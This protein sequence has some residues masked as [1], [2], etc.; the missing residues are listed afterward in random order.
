MTIFSG[1]I[2]KAA[3]TRT[4]SVG[5]RPTFVTDFNIAENYSD[6]SGTRQTQFYRVSL[7][8]DAGTKLAKYLTLGRP[9]QL[10]GRVKGRGYLTQA[11]V[12]QIKAGADWRTLKIPCQLEMS[13]PR[14]TFLTANPTTEVDDGAAVE[15]ELPPVDENDKPF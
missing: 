2:S 4:V 1:N 11:I 6:G 12:D 8:R 9:V 14:V 10:E 5:G 7:W 3:D 13:N 15:A